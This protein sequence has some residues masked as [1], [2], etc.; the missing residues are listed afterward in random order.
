LLLGAL[1]LSVQWKHQTDTPTIEAEM[2]SATALQAAAKAVEPP[3]PPPAPLPVPKPLPEPVT[4]PPPV[5]AAA[6][7]PPPPSVRDA[8]IAVERQKAKD[9]ALAEEQQARQLAERKRKDDLKK[10]D[11]LDAE[12]K[13]AEK[14][15][16]KDKARKREADAKLAA[17][18][19]A[20]QA[21]ADKA[22]KAKADKAKTDKANAAAAKAEADARYKAQMDRMMGM[23]GASGDA[24]ATGTALKSSAPSANYGG[25]IIGRVK[26]NIVFAD[27][28]PGN[29]E[30]LVEFRT[31]PDGTIVGTP[32]LLKSSGVKAWDEAV[33]NAILK[34]EV[35]PRDTDGR[36]PPVI[37]MTFK[38]KDVR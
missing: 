26:P 24:K 16:E 31:A 1:T 3:P 5:K 10:R 7:T 13:L 29:P 32:K 8:Q 17:D 27:D 4:V 33:I 12:K 6:P 36:V 35:I 19:E 25:R 22:D 23:A 20:A 9:K 38:P 14:E 28:L 18:K 15:K 37:Q 34:T 30:A 2:W 21:K 11:K